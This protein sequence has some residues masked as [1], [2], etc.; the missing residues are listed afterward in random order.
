MIQYS[1]ENYKDIEE[2]IST[3]KYWEDLLVKE[4]LKEHLLGLDFEFP[5]SG[6]YLFY[7]RHSEADFPYDYKKMTKRHSMNFSVIILDND[8]KTIIYIEKDT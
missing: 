6:Y 2:Q 3:Q 5:Q 7:D 1:N 8:A 4:E